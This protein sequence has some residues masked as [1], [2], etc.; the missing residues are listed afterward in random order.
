LIVANDPRMRSP[1]FA[2]TLG[3]DAVA[4]PVERYFEACGATSTTNNDREPGFYFEERK[5]L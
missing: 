1:A 5:D 4:I 3:C 2:G